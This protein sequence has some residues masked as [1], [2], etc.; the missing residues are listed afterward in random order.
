[1]HRHHRDRLFLGLIIAAL[2]ALWKL[3]TWLFT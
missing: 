2:I 3:T 1:M